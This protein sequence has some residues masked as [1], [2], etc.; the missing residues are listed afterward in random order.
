M[1]NFTI[2]DTNIEGL[3]IIIT[4]VYK[5]HR[6]FFTETWQKKTFEQL[7]INA[8]F[9]Q[10]NHSRSKKGVLRGIHFQEKHKQ[11]KLV[12][13]IRGKIMDIAVDL[14]EGSKTFGQHYKV[15]L[16]D[17]NHKLL[18]IPEGFGHGFLS[19]ED[20][21]ELFYKTTDYYCPNCESGIFYN[22]IDLKIDWQSKEF[23]IDE[24]ILSEKDKKL[25]TLTEWLKNRDNKG[26]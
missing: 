8:D 16:S 6:G 18:F 1:S 25:P 5:D 3:T 10:D 24:M 22:D 12:R 11:A 9:V 20:D 14:R 23:G 2:Q 15:I 13:C 19:L 17:T 26:L 7:G 21:S 4:L